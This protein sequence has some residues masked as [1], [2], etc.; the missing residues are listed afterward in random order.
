MSKPYKYKV[1]GGDGGCYGPNFGPVNAQEIAEIASD[2]T[3]YLL[4]KLDAPI[5][6]EKDSIDYFVVSPRYVGD[7]LKKLRRRGCHVG[8]GRV[9][10]NQE[11][12][13]RTAGISE[14]TVEYWAIGVCTPIE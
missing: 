6:H 7:S 14:A 1:S 4:L 2:R 13:V 12:A 10:P 3:S 11:Q 8:V 5:K 9:L